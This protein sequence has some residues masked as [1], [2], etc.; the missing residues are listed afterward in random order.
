MAKNSF[1][2]KGGAKDHKSISNII[3]MNSNCGTSTLSHEQIYGHDDGSSLL[4]LLLVSVDDD[5]GYT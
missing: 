3:I 4:L 2:L 5:D 1:S